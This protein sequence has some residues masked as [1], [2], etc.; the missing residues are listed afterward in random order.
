[1]EPLAIASVEGLLLASPTAALAP[2]PA[3]RAHRASTR[4]EDVFGERMSV[5]Q[6]PSEGLVPVPVKRLDPSS[7]LQQ[8]SRSQDKSGI[9]SVSHPPESMDPHPHL[10]EWVS[11]SPPRWQEGRPREVP[12]F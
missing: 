7:L 11:K 4:E 10:D 3:V 1:M 12:A 2:A 6:I 5:E 9:N 8:L